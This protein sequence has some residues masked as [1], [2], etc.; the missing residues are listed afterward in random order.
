[1]PI[2]RLNYTKRKKLTRDQVRIRLTPNGDGRPRTFHAD[3]TLPPDLPGDARVFVEAYRSSPAARMRFD[4]GTVDAVRAPAPDEA[5]L[6]DFNDDL[7]PPLFRVKVTDA[8]EAPGK[9]LAEAH[10][11]RPFDPD[12]KP[13][14]RRGIL[15]TAWRHLD[16]TVWEL[17]LDG[18]VGPQLF[19]DLTA[20]PNH[21]LPGR[22]YFKALVYPEVIRRVLTFVLIENDGAYVDDT[23]SWHGRWLRFPREMYGFT[24]ETPPAD[25]S[26]EDKRAW[27]DDAVKFCARKAGLAQAM[28]PTEEPE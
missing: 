23:T 1:M 21:E 2:R 7:P 12:E 14:Q 13:D 10:Q 24:E 8:R 18:T 15:F 11:I 28:A 6:T 16:G 17:D 4:F 3:L 22:T 25:A 27:I 5:R 19:I 20:D 26:E 9:L